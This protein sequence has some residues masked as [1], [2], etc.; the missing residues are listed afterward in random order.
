[1]FADKSL[2]SELDLSIRQALQLIANGER[3]DPMLQRLLLD[4]LLHPDRS[5]LPQDPNALVSAAA[6]SATQWIGVGAEEREKVL[7]ELLDLADALRPHPSRQHSLTEKVSAVHSSLREA[8]LPHA[9]GGAI[10][11]GYYG[12]PR[13][14]GDI[15]VNVFVPTARWPEIRDVLNPLRI[16]AQVDEAELKRFNEMQLE[17]D[18]NFL[19]L[20]FSADALHQRMSEAIR[21][22]PFDGATIPIVSPEHLVVR[23]AQ[24]DRT[25]D[26]PDIEQI[27][28]ASWPL[29]FEEIET[30]LGRLTGIDDPR[31]EKLRE[32][33]TSLSLS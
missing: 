2:L 32:V 3:P 7:R 20:F 25:K 18:S 11:V 4:A 13:S 22:V 12:E 14:T 27:L 15:D 8:G 31:M 17:W 16:D 29:D 28:V 33:K 10:A 26:W 21:L 1:V 19:H 9:I 6:R 5:D 30:S 23:K 24:L